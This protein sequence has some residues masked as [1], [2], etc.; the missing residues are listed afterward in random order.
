MSQLTQVEF[1]GE[2][3]ILEAKEGKTPRF[4]IQAYNGGKLPVKGH[5]YPV[6]VE[7]SSASFERDVTKINRNHDQQ[8]ELGHTDQQ[9]IDASGIFLAGPLSV[10]SEDQKEIIQASKDGFPWDA[11][12]EATFPKP[13]LIAQGKSL[14]V[15]GRIQS[16]PF[17]YAQNAIITGT[18]IL[19]RGADRN[20]VVTIA[21]QEKELEMEALEAEVKAEKVEANSAMEYAKKYGFDYE[22]LTPKQ[23]SL[24]S[25]KMM[26][27]KEVKAKVKAKEMDAGLG[28]GA[29]TKR[30]NAKDKKMVA[31]EYREQLAAETERAAEIRSICAQYGNPTTE[32]NGEMVSLEASAIR[33]P[34]MSLNEVRLEAKLYDLDQNGGGGG[35]PFNIHASKPL[36]TDLHQETLCAAMAQQHFGIT[37]QQAGKSYGEKAMNEAAS[38][39]FRGISLHGVMETIC[40]AAGMSWGSKSRGTM[41]FWQHTRDAQQRLE[42]SGTSTLSLPSLFE[43]VLNKTQLESFNHVQGMWREIAYVDTVKDFKPIS[44]VRLT[45]QGGYREV[46]KDGEIKHVTLS[47]TQRGNQAKTYGAMMS[48]TRQDIINDDLGALVNVSRYLGSMAAQR[49][50]EIVWCT[51]LG[52]VDNF[53]SA[54]NKN[55][56]TVELGL[57]ELSEVRDQFV[58]RV[59]SNNKPITIGPSMLLHG[60]PLTDL[61]NDLYTKS[62][63]AISDTTGNNG[64]RNSTKNNHNGK[65]KPVMSQYLSNTDI[66]DANGKPIKNQ[67][68]NLWFLMAQ[69]TPMLHALSIVFLNGNQTPTTSTSDMEFNKLGIQYRSYHDFGVAYGDPEAVVMSR[70]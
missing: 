60:V 50:E 12:I 57:D 25:K 58:N 52:N 8:R 41:D 59:D 54:A 56:A 11:S 27:E 64:L 30:A 68:D 26:A 48:L 23:K 24:F 18:A 33:D 15:N 17:L 45:A 40:A 66:R 20:T 14:N 5:R 28:D 65:Y 62:E 31:Q 55:L 51:L 46:G 44:R 70:P 39:D 4:E 29:E 9:T 36:E 53:F 1:G 35:S 22:S 34:D 49:I 10:P 47:D 37:E 7:L 2:L 42:A 67:A 69:S 13:V 63:F 43:N 19:N 3:Q 16:G 38:K 6:V 21:A 61:A 32:V